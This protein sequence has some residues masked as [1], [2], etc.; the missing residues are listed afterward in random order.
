MVLDSVLYYSPEAAVRPFKT[1]HDVPQPALTGYRLLNDRLVPLEVWQTWIEGNVSL[2]CEDAWAQLPE[3]EITPA[4][5][6]TAESQPYTLASTGINY[7]LHLSS[8]QHGTA[9]T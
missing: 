3:P 9:S 6:V 8:S 1:D 2:S 7:S 4:I 5:D